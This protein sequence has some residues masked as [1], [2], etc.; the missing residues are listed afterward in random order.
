V[1]KLKAQIGHGQEE[2]PKVTFKVRF[3]AK[4][5]AGPTLGRPLF[6]PSGVAKAGADASLCVQ[7]LLGHLGLENSAFFDI[8]L[9]EHHGPRELRNAIA[10][11]RIQ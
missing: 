4:G 9:A 6:I 7:I 2:M 11:W 8:N 3:N 1:N 10:I 5:S